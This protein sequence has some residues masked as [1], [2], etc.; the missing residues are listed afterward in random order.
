MGPW[1]E[2]LASL[3]HSR[4]GHTAVEVNGSL[5]IHGGYTRHPFL[6]DHIDVWQLMLQSGPP[7]RWQE[8]TTSGLRPKRRAHSAVMLGE[9]MLVFGGHYDSDRYI[10]SGFYAGFSI[11]VYPNGLWQLTF[12]QDGSGSWSELSTSQRRPPG[13]SHHT[14]VT[15]SDGS[16]L[17]FG[18]FYWQPEQAEKYM[19]DAWRFQLDGESSGIWESLSTNGGP[20]ARW[21][22]AAVGLLDGSMLI[23]G[24]RA[25]TGIHF[26]DMWLLSLS[27]GSTHVWSELRVAGARPPPRSSTRAA[28]MADGSVILFGTSY[29][30]KPNDLWRLTMSQGSP[31]WTELELS[32][33][34][35]PDLRW[36]HTVVGAADGTLLVVGG[37]GQNTEIQYNDVWRLHDAIPTTTTTTKTS[38]VSTTVCF[39]QAESWNGTACAACDAGYNS[40]GCSTF[41]EPTLASISPL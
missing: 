24:G 25:S 12:L 20:E 21:D 41:C 2:E 19:S 14:A 33:A 4:T 38:T 5:V 15:V 3:S 22:H 35:R 18:G 39:C 27:Q 30:S 6:I 7:Y 40:P 17:V 8:L 13:R 36:R 16:M 10:S 1:W 37:F 26:D 11:Q 34:E 29:G 9:K 23:F 32:S 31:S 28:R